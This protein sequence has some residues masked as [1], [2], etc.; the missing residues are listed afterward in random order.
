VV[1]GMMIIIAT[2]FGKEVSFEHIYPTIVEK[3]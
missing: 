3:S 2:G 1:V